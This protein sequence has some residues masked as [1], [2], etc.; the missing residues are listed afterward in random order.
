MNLSKNR[1]INGELITLEQA[2]ELSNL[3]K[4]VVRRLANESGA[5]LKIGNAYRI[6]KK[7]FFN[8]IKT[9]YTK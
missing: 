7:V 9:K 3:G 6:D 8:H 2:C 5:S 1:N 4:T